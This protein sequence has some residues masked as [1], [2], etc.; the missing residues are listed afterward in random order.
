MNTSSAE[1]PCAGSSRRP[2]LVGQT[3]QSTGSPERL[4]KG[5][6]PSFDEDYHASGFNGELEYQ[7]GGPE[8]TRAHVTSTNVPRNGDRREVGQS[9]LYL[10]AVKGCTIDMVVRVAM[11][12]EWPRYGEHYCSGM[13]I[14][15]LCISYSANPSRSSLTREFPAT[16]AHR[17]VHGGFHSS[18][19]VFVLY[20]LPAGLLF[21]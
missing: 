17:E 3:F 16:Y 11:A 19:I 18:G 8:S 7:T 9:V 20:S 14:P 6:N 21:P 10:S 13:A 15:R 1:A 2:S 4:R 12:Q 5:L